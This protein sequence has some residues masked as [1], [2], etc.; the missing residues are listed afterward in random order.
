MNRRSFHEFFRA[1]GLTTLG[2]LLILVFNFV[3][4]WHLREMPLERDEGEYA[5]AGQLLLQGASPYEHAYTVMLKLP[6]TWVVYAFI[7]AVFGQTATAIHV[8]VIA[9]N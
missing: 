9:I 2:L 5:Y 1:Y 3:I 4:R 6:G 8:G 7:M